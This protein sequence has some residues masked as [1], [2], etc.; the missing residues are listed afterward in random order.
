MDNKPS[1][2]IIKSNK[3]YDGKSFVKVAN[4]DLETFKK[5]NPQFKKVNPKL[6]LSQ[7]INIPDWGIAL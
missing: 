6:V 4:I 1:F 2:V 7:S 5:Y 3:A